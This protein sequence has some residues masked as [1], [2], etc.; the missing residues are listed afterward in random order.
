[1]PSK[2]YFTKEISS[3]KVVE[4]FKKLNVELTGK[5]ALKVHSGENQG[6]YFLKPKVLLLN[7]IL[8]MI[9]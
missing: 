2:V 5:V 8:L 9:N 3:E 6:K 7:V 1:M 4:I